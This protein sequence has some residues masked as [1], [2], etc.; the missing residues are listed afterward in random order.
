[1][2]TKV[3]VIIPVYNVEKYLRDCLECV[4]N[5]TL[6]DIEIICVDDGSTDESL[7]ILH[8]YEEKDARVHVLTQK[9]R[10]A[11]VARNHGMEIATGEY[12]AFW[13][14]DDLFELNA[15]EEMYRHAAEMKADICLCGS[16]R[17]DTVSLKHEKMPWML[18]LAAVKE[19]PFC[20]REVKTIFQVTAPAP[21]SKLFS[22]SFVRAHELQFQDTVR[23]NDMYFVYSALALAERIVYVDKTFIHYR[24]GQTV[25]LQSGVV[26]S[27]DICCS[28]H[29][30]LCA[31]LK[32]EA[33]WNGIKASF[34]QCVI[35]NLAYNLKLVENNPDS[36]ERLLA[37]L[38]EGYFEFLGFGY[39][40]IGAIK[41]KR[42]FNKVFL[43]ILKR[44]ADRP[45]VPSVSVA[46]AFHNNS[47]Y[48]GTCI[49]SV[50]S[51]TR[52]DIEL[53]CVD[54]CSADNTLELL[55]EYEARDPRIRI[56]AKETN[57]GT[58]MARK[59]GALAANGRYIMFL[60]SD[61]FLDPDA[62]GT[63]FE[64]SVRRQADILQISIGVEDH[65][66]DPAAKAWL[67]DYLKAGDITCTRSEMQKHFY[68]DR[69]IATS[70]VGKLYYAPKCKLAYYSIPDIYCVIGE[71]IFQQ[72]FFSC[73]SDL[74]CGVSTRPLYWYRRGLGDS[75]SSVMS[76]QKFEK[77]CNMA[78][79]YRQMQ[80]FS[81]ENRADAVT[82]S[83]VSAAGRR[84][85]ED[86]CRIWNGRI[87]E[88]DKTEAFEVLLRSWSIFP[89]F[90]G[91]LEKTTG[92]PY[93]ELIK[94]WRPV[95][96]YSSIGKRY[97]G[98]EGP[99]VS[100]VIPVYNVEAYL[101]ACIE[102]VLRQSFREVE[103]IGINDGSTDDSLKVLEEYAARDDRITVISQEN[104]GLSVT[105]NVGL[106]YVR[107]EYLLFLDSDD[108]L[109]PDSI[110]KL[111][112]H[113]QEEKLDVLFF[114]AEVFFE[115]E[116]LKKKHDNYDNYYASS[117]YYPKDSGQR[118]FVMLRR[119]HVY[120]ESA[121]LQFL[122]TDFVKSNALQFF[123]GIVHED[124]L[125]TFKVCM[126]AA[127]A[128]K[129]DEN[130]YL[131]RIRENSIM[132]TPSNFRNLY[133][134]LKTFAQMM[135]FV[136]LNPLDPECEKDILYYVS[137]IRK[138]VIQF[139]QS[140][141]ASEMKKA[142]QLSREDK[143]WF[144]LISDTAKGGYASDISAL[145]QRAE[146]A[147]QYLDDVHH[148]VSFR[149]GRAITW[150]P[151]KLRGG[152]RCLRDN[153]PQYTFW[154]ALYHLGIKHE[155]DPSN[156]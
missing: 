66:D 151:R 106:T 123:P 71:D 77:Y 95:P 11:G 49:E 3:S 45:G 122:R 6:K 17:F 65:A 40:D 81:A 5:Q 58:L 79:L 153:G 100:V 104:Q 80:M 113:A 130:F 53:I 88:E 120:R 72:F 103:I 94:K 112:A 28:V 27:P 76:V 109:A 1:M 136:E 148:S 12:F 33:V 125:F 87:R 154:R 75:N 16:D 78:V 64:E 93:A 9:N 67:E 126:L 134:Y 85:C 10:Y 23:I 116:L 15:L 26:K 73:S 144:N 31:R 90:T 41:D 131:R 105:R 133:G 19:E 84:M 47:E 155:G 34:Y 138:R 32:D 22:A 18:N 61:D 117:Q 38:D 68:L 55:R 91:I 89:E 51:Q 56:I 74:F 121:C 149:V 118:L 145:E 86:C 156:Y 24:S 39:D 13:D 115:N 44:R 36:K 83:A 141:P 129:L 150:A 4:I 102:S 140:L 69:D 107:G 97:S 114:G 99:K 146:Q 54:D 98:D 92:A 147:E 111:Y 30:A 132:T 63:M 48:V 57:C 70:V 7:A 60:D 2:G 137:Q 50:L 101:S 8:E 139:T 37:A 82:Q 128:A 135:A 124:N 20:A 59:S 110:E 143:L 43:E 108:M 52:K 119:D 25:N 29:R 96:V 152:V 35:E 46:V 142:A 14:S 21:W 62:C 42:S 127:Q